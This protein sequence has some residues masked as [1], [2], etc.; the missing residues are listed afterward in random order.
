M[1]EEQLFAKTRDLNLLGQPRWPIQKTLLTFLGLSLVM[2]LVCAA[3]TVYNEILG[4]VMSELGSTLFAQWIAAAF[5]LTCVMVQ[6]VWVKLAEKFG[7]LWPLLASVAIFM[8]FSVMV[9][10]AQSMVALCVGRALQGVGG[11]GM[12]PLSLVVLTDIL[13][14]GERGV[15]MGFL[16]AVI[17]LGK[18]TGPAIG[19]A[20]HESSTWRWAG[21][22][23]LPVGA[24]ALAILFLTLRDLPTP[25]GAVKRKIRE[26]DYLGT[27]LW[28]GGSTMILLGLS[29]GGNEHAW[30]SAIVV[31]L[32]VFGF[33]VIL[34]FGAVEGKWAKWPIIPLRMLARPR[35]LLPMISS[36][37]IG[38]CLYGMI[39]FVPIYYSTVL[40]QGA[41]QSVRHLLWCALGGC[42]G[43]LVA[44]SLVQ[45]RRRWYYREW[46]VLG[47]AMMTVG[48]GLMYVWP[49]DGEAKAKHAGYQV[50]I[51]LGLG[52]SMQ[53]VLLSAQAGLPANEISTATTLIDYA[54]TLGGMVGLVIGEVILK[55]KVFQAVNAMGFGSFVGT[56]TGGTDFVQL[57]SMLP[58]LRML[59]SSI[60]LP[61]YEGIV[62]A[63]HYVYV[64]DVPFAGTA[65]ILCM[66]VSNVPLHHILPATN[67]EELLETQRNLHSSSDD[68]KEQ[69]LSQ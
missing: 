22:Y 54:R 67:S 51:G 6:P 4:T 14:P 66:L 43:A 63:I 50:L 2:F 65:C 5:L 27:I 37:L 38:F 32:F 35:V 41:L 61:I 18:W 68:G 13:S 17:V 48:F 21:Y 10:A 26:F 46:A 1:D 60:S 20:L 58:L 8:V 52:F 34:L 62:N 25:P 24:V 55:E 36:F 28:M 42:V 30:R 31:C 15:Y 29:L 11:A 64:T 59:P 33:I 45:V 47:T 23:N 39:M 3:E 69:L 56:A 53:Q 12:M 9:G 40:D 19:A 57:E 16:G 44:G 49:L 7:R